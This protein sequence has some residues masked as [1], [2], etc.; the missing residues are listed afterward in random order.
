MKRLYWV[1]SGE[2]AESVYADS[3]EDA[4]RTALRTTKAKTFG[5]LMQVREYSPRE[6]WYLLTENV[7]K[8][9]GWKQEA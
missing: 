4:A 9:I 3:V 8:E 7:C 1:T 2:M 6:D 5:L